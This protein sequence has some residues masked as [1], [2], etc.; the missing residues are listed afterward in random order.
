MRRPILNAVTQAAQGFEF[1]IAGVHQVFMA[2]LALLVV[3]FLP[4]SKVL[5]LGFGAE[6][7][8]EGK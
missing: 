4:A 1:E 6:T 2:G 3:Q 5:G 7:E 8:G